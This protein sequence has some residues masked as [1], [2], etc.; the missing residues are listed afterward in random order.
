MYESFYDEDIMP[1]PKDVTQATDVKTDSTQATEVK[2]TESA[3]VKQPVVD[4]DAIVA[5]VIKSIEAKMTKVQEPKATET[6]VVEEDDFEKKLAAYE[7]KKFV[8]NLKEED[9]T[10]LNGL[11]AYDSLSVEQLNWIISKIKAGSSA[12]VTKKSFPTADNT[13]PTNNTASTVED[14]VKRFKEKE[15]KMKKNGGK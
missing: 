1:E 5:T 13:A 9:K 3:D 14:Y 4:I 8:A 2:G 6:K 7:K 10:L 12:E 11:P 15:A